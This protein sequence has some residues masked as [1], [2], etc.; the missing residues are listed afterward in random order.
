MSV[1]H[2]ISEQRPT[3]ED[4][5]HNLMVLV[6]DRWGVAKVIPWNWCDLGGQYIKWTRIPREED[7][8]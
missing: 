8:E 3:R 7:Y 5:D 4:A 2:F 1:W 6:I